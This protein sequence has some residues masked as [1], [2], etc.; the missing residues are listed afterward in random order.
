MIA[1]PHELQNHMLQNI[2]VAVDSIN[3][4]CSWHS[5]G[6]KGKVSYV[7]ANTEKG[8]LVRYRYKGADEFHVFKEWDDKPK[9]YKSAYKTTLSKPSK[10]EPDILPIMLEA[11]H[12]ASKVS[13]DNE[14]I[15]KKLIVPIGIKEVSQKIVIKPATTTTREQY[16]SKGTLLIPVH[17]CDSGAIQGF[18][19]IAPNGTKIMR[20]K[21]SKG[22]LLIGSSKLNTG[23]LNTLFIAEGY[24]TAVSV[25]MRTRT[26]CIC[27]FSAGGLM[28]AGLFA[29]SKYPDANIIFAADND[30]G[31]GKDN[32]GVYYA[33]LAAKKVSGSVILPEMEG[34]ADFNDW[35]ILQCLQNEKSR[36]TVEETRPF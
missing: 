35:H 29:R 33:T 1:A 34:K 30:G 26:T 7:T 14:Y 15:D 18:E 21:K 16:L 2:G 5:A 11:W 32:T 13:L 28:D 36:E 22:Y 4:D 27:A 6:K 31:K 17:N 8:L 20:G 3:N 12:S 10:P 24:S 25:H 23:E 19:T 9:D